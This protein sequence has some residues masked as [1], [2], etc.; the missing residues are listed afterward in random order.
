MS[1]NVMTIPRFSRDEIVRFAG[2]VGR[3]KSYRPNSNTWTYIVE[4]EMGPEPDFGRVGGET[5]LVLEEADIQK[6]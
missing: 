3:I 2:V 1:S 4:M 6:N 5:T